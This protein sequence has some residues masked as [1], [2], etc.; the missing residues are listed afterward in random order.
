MNDQSILSLVRFGHALRLEGVPVGPERIR[1]FCE[2]AAAIAPADLYWAGRAS[3]LWGP[4]QIPIYDDVFQ[5]FF[6]Q[7]SEPQSDLDESVQALARPS[8]RSADVDHEAESES[9]AGTASRNEVLQE[10]S[11][12]LCTESDWS[13]LAIL[14]HA[15]PGMLPVQRTRRY[16]RGPHG[17][18]DVRR[19]LRRAAATGGEPLSIRE[20]HRRVTVRPLVFLLDVSGSMAAY[21]RGYL[22]FAH[23]LA[24]TSGNAEVY[25]FGTRLTNLTGALAKRSFDEALL[26][27]SSAV[28]DWDGGTR[29]GNALSAFLDERR[30]RSD[31][32]RAVT[33]ICSDGLDTGDPDL[34]ARETARLR[35]TVHRLVWLNPLKADV[36]YEPLTRGM[37]AA[38]PHL[39]LFESGHSLGSLLSVLER[40]GRI[41]GHAVPALGTTSHSWFTRED[42]SRVQSIDEV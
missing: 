8:V 26:E 1:V 42:A 32:R 7:V 16:Q 36:R 25:A 4:D 31:T 38:H 3:L 33:F 13:E 27:A 37:R 39:D 23:A 34:L 2:A 19:V 6:G 29:I 5:R 10:K 17:P 24:R 15:L 21:S 41:E 18:I 14:F 35:R 28:P 9:A 30:N 22:M 20:R 40:I 12:E 11:F